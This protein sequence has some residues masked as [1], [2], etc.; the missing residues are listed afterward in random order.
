MGSLTYSMSVSLDGFAAATDGSLDWVLVDDELHAHFNDEAARMSGSLYG[1]RMYELMAG[2]WPTAESDPDA[3]PV[4]KAFARIWAATPK[5]V[6][7][8][9]L[10]HVD[11]NSRLVRGDTIAE[12]VRLKAEPGFD[13]DVGGPTL[14]GSLLRA[15]LIDEVQVYL[16]PVVLGAGLP[17]FPLLDTPLRTRLVETRAFG[18]GVVLLRY[19]T[20]G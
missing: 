2:Y 4:M 11:W 19:E 1:R 5:I 10:D 12:V 9:T 13:M 14:A 18:S 15:R 7:S 20:L 6:F 8:S 16:Q 3:T 17:F